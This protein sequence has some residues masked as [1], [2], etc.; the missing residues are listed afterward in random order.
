MEI[1]ISKTVFDRVSR[2]LVKKCR[3]ILPFQTRSHAC[4]VFSLIVYDIQSMRSTA[5]SHL[6]SGSDSRGGGGSHVLGLDLLSL[7]L[8]SLGSLLSGLGL[9]GGGLLLDGLLSG[10]LFGGLLLRLGGLALDGGTELGEGAVLALLLTFDGGRGLVALAESEG[11]GRL[12]LLLDVLLDLSDSLRHGG[13]GGL[14]GLS[15]GSSNIDGEGSGGLDGRDHGSSLSG[16]RLL[17]SVS[18]LGGL[19]LRGLLLLLGEDATE[20]AVA[21]GGGG[22]LLGGLNGLLLGGLVLDSRG[23]LS[24]G[25]LLDDGGGLLDLGGLLDNSRSLIDLG[26]LLSDGGLLNGLGLLLLFLLLAEAE[27]RSTL[28]AS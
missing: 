27:E 5:A 23:L 17:G 14:G 10:F 15:G 28:A 22:L 11:E 18:G 8:L 19:E 12:A 2:Y 7:G 21:L 25:G 24:L 9:L 3:S 13:L 26:S 20:E 4:V 6:G 1:G 16:L